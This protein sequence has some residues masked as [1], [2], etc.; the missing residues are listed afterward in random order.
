MTDP[1]AA[2]LNGSLRPELAIARLLLDGETPEAICARV[3]AARSDS[4][5]WA[6]LDRLAS[7][8]DTLRRLRRMLEAAG[9]DHAEPATPAAIAALFD[10][11]VAIS[12]EASVAFYSLGDPE[13]LAAT[14]EEIV[15]WL[16]QKDLL[17]PGTDVLDLGCGIGRIA[18]AIAR[19]VRTVHAIDS[20]G[21]MVAEARRRCAGIPNA[22]VAL[23]RGSDLSGIGKGSF[24]LILAVDS[25]PY[26]VQAGVA[27][28]HLLDAR[29]I[30]RPGGALVALNLAYAPD[31]GR[32]DARA[33]AT[34]IGYELEA[35]TAS[36]FTLWDGLPFI[37]RWS[38]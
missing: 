14:T 23:T 20:S 34:S 37:F 10:G 24:D 8:P 25:F 30:L 35:P 13:R 11:A 21:G 2:C 3:E 27:Q 29:R 22:T 26:L 36:P 1:L 31:L 4:A 16:M 32:A 6:E 12:P 18:A 38:A 15:A 9:V 17:R 19:Y 7:N 5:G 33:W 28:R